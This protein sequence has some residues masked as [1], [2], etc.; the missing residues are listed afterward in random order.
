MLL[1]FL[2]LAHRAFCAAAILAR[3]SALIRRRFRARG[4]DVVVVLAFG[5]PGPRLAGAPVNSSLARSRR[6]ISESISARMFCR[7]TY[8]PRIGLI[9]PLGL[10]QYRLQ[11]AALSFATNGKISPVGQRGQL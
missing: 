11:D 3:P 7:F 1:A 6:E 2:A 5:L 8:S 10:D 4:A 9:A